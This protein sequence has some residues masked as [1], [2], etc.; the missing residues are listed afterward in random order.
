MFV[1]VKP[2]EAIGFTCSAL[3]VNVTAVWPLDSEWYGLAN[4]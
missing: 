2:L 3:A 4:I 1:S